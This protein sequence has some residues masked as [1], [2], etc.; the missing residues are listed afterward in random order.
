M[1]RPAG[2]VQYSHPYRLEVSAG[3]QNLAGDEN[4]SPY[5]FSFRTRCADDDLGS[6]PPR[7][8]DLVTG[9]IPTEPPPL[10][11]TDAGV[12]DAGPPAEVDQGT[13]LAPRGGGGCAL[14]MQRAGMPGA[15]LPLFALG[16]LMGLLVFRSRRR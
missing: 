7:P 4:T 1:L 8:P 3:V 14:V 15:A 13:P 9:P 12:P 5:T 16:S 10:P 2:T 11:T 6:C